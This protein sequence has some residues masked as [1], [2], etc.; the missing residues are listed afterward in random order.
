MTFDAAAWGWAYN[1]E[2]HFKGILYVLQFIMRLI[3][4]GVF[5]FVY[6]SFQWFKL[7]VENFSLVSTAYSTLRS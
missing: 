2:V 5:H 3:S 7:T 6:K 4:L 1:F